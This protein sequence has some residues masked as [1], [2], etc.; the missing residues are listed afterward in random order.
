MDCINNVNLHTFGDPKGAVIGRYGK[1][2]IT[3]EFLAIDD[4]YSFVYGHEEDWMEHINC[5][6]DFVAHWMVEGDGI[7]H[8]SSYEKYFRIVLGIVEVGRFFNYTDYHPASFYKTGD[9]FWLREPKPQRS[10]EPE[11]EL[12]LGF[13][14]LNWGPNPVCLEPPKEDEPWK[15]C[16]FPDPEGH[17]PHYVSDFEHIYSANS[18]DDG[19]PLS[20]MR[21]V[22]GYGLSH[23]ALSH[24]FFKKCRKAYKKRIKAEQEAELR[25][26]EAQSQSESAVAQ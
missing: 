18:G 23:K 17:K 22:E 3:P 24:K 25:K 8:A 13:H 5:L 2:A 14:L 4:F 1:G 19:Y 12:G 16:G 15:R 10:S 26:S 11:I 7:K 9:C 20:P 6:L 21:F